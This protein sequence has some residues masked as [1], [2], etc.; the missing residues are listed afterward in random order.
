MANG[1]HAFHIMRGAKVWNAW[2]KKNPDI[3]P[4]LSGA[5]LSE[6]NLGETN[7][8]ETNLS[9]TNLSET[10]LSR[11]DLNGV[12]LNGADLNSADLSGANLISADLRGANL[13]EADL[14][15]ATLISADLRG[16][17][18]SEATLIRTDLSGANLSGANLSEATLIRT[19]LSDANLSGA[20]LSEADLSRTNLSKANLYYVDLR[21]AALIDSQLDDADLSG[22]KLWETQRG[23]WSIKDVTCQRAFWDRDGE[24]P[25]EYEDGAFERI[26]AEE[27][28]IVLRYAGGMSPVDLAMLPLIIERLQAEH[29]GNSLHIRSVQDDGSGATV[30]IIVEDLAGR[31]NEAIAQDV[32]LMRGDLAT[33]QQRLQHEERLRLQAEA[34]Y[35]TMVQDVLPMLMERV[36]PKTEIH[37]G[38]ITA[39]TIIEGTTMSGDTYNNHGLAG[40]FGSN[41]HAHDMTI[42]QVQ[43]QATLDLPPLA[44]ELKRLRAAMKKADGKDDQD[45]AIGA[46]AAAEKA[47]IKGDGPTVLSH[48]KSAGE[49]TLGI[50]EKLGVPLIVEAMKRMM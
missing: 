30:T 3:V 20:N 5:D 7:L 15:S 1:Y 8:G 50:A 44:E 46:V 35:R 41:P 19:D 32:E 47:A 22:A 17:N 9:E 6:T 2:R 49:W 29:P 39:P 12:D 24:E 10:N 36:L 23:G 40:A 34:S 28:R 27:P 48:L 42:Q 13:S 25:T 43:N 31:S 21:A 45:E 16:A 14:S 4:D 33:L 18:L 38:K 26:F 11:S 37:I